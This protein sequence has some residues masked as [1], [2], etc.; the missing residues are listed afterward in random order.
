VIL[1]AGLTPAWQEIK[2]FDTFRYGEVNRAREVHW[3]PSGKVFNAAIGCHHLGAPTRLLAPAGGLPLAKIEQE[4]QDM[5][6]SYRLIRTEASTRICT[7]ILEESTGA[8]TELV[9]N[10]RPLRPEELDQFRRAYC[11]EVARAKIVILIGSLPIGTPE[12]LYR[13]LL[14]RTPCPTVLDFRGQ[15]LVSVLDLKPLVVKPNREE[16]AGTV[17]R[18]LETDEQL[19]GAM[20]SLNDRGAQWVVITQGSGPVW[21]TSRREAYR[22]IPAKPERVVNP[23]ASGDAVAATIAWAT[24]DGRPM[25]DAVRLGIAAA[26]QNLR[27]L[28]PCRL[29][30]T[31]LEREAERVRVEEV[32]IAAFNKENYS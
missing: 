9:E 10:G 7:T 23:I 21:V 15:G 13:E 24:L 22:L 32:T 27:S 3:F 6:L 1:C 19:L 31:R 5:G 12:S 28:L 11:E 26:G 17:G 2:V 18:P 8:V 25:V 14:E 16:L 29:D 20:R 4:F 30:P